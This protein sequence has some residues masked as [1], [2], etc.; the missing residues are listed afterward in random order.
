MAAAVPTVDR[1]LTVAQ[2]DAAPAA[3]V[4]ELLE[5]CLDIPRWVD[6]L[7]ARRPYRRREALL[8]Q[9]ARSAD[10]VRWDEVAGALAR[11]P[12]IGQTPSGDSADARLSATEQSGVRPAEKRALAEGNATYEKRFGHI[13]LDLRQRSRAA[14]RCSPRC[15]NGSPTTSSPNGAWWSRNSAR[16][17]RSGC[18]RR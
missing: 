12:R 3:E 10:Q 2:F 9:A 7:T 5:A 4:R 11:H 18:R 16:S 6:E 13:Y 17:R 8:E 1:P 14:N 15:S